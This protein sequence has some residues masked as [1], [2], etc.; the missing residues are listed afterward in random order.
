[1]VNIDYRKLIG[2]SK[3]SFVVT[4][5]KYWVEKHNLKKGDMISIEEGSD[6]L[7]FY[8]GEKETKKE[9]KSISISAEDKKLSMIKAEIVSSYLNN[10]NTIE[11]FSKTLEDDAPVIKGI[12]RNLSG[13]EI[14]EQTGKRIV[15]KDLIDVSSISIQ[16]IIR[17]MDVI[18]RSMIDD[19]IMC[20]QG[21]CNPK[22]I[23]HRDT[24]VNRLYYLGFRVIKNAMENPMLMNKLETNPWRL[25]SDK[26]ILSRIE[27]IAD[28]QKRVSRLLAEAEFKDK[29]LEEFKQI[30]NEIKERY[31]NA[32]K[33][34]YNNDKKIAYDIE[35][36]TKN[37][38]EKCDKFLE[39]ISKLLSVEIKK[40]SEKP[41]VLSKKNL[42]PI[43]K[44]LDYTKSNVTF[45]KYI[46]RAVLNMD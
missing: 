45:I 23:L 1:M 4:M 27:E 18:T 40:G 13:M 12:L 33:A 39:N 9:E 41:T 35:I 36:T 34:Y 46:A 8:A 38:I 29:I 2:F 16:S 6:E 22:S 30:S 3:G 37:Y 43:Y 17:R 11:I 42:V 44:I 14:I 31:N 26:M 32:M 21:K 28:R 19:T 24:D 25:L 7:V 10:Y 20:M 5:P 15:A